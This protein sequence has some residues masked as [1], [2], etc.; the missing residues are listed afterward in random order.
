MGSCIVSCLAVCL[1]HCQAS[2]L[3]GCCSFSNNPSPVTPHHLSC[4]MMCFISAP[5]S[6]SVLLGAADTAEM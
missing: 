2:A 3:P 4:T 6:V 1:Q 5:G